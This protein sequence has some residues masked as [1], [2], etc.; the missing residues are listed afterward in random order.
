MQFR[1]PLIIAIVLGLAAAILNFVVIGGK[2]KTIK[3]ERD[4]WH[5]K[6]QT[7]DAELTQTK[8]ELETTKEKLKT[9]ESEVASLKTERDNAVA[10][11]Q[12]QREQAANISKQLQTARQEIND[13]QTRLAQWDALGISPDAIRSLQ[14]YAKKLEETNTNLLQQIDHL[15]Y[16]YYRATNE[17][18]LYKL[19]DYTPSVP[20]DVVGRVLAVDPKWGFVV[21]SVG[22]DDGVVE[23]SQL[24]IS[25]Q[26]KLVAKVRVKSVDKN[27][28][29][30]NVI[31]EWKFGEIFEGDLVIP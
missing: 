18:A 27:S 24:L 19:A 15:K 21:L 12:A 8:S 6:Y 23:Q 9:V 11:A 22:L 10:E 26:G 5:T 7:T 31:P 30:A 29:I 2:I 25:R 14:N 28:C 4:D 16:Q 13:L 1:V 20:P 17:L 3:A